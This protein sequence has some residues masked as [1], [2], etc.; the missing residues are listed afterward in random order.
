MLPTRPDGPARAGQPCALETLSAPEARAA[1][2]GSERC[3]PRGRRGGRR[4]RA[5]AGRRAVHRR[6]PERLGAVPG[7]GLVPRRWVRDRLGVALTRHV[8]GSGRRRGVHRHLCRLP[9]A[10]ST[11]SRRLDDALGVTRW[12]RAHAAELGG[13]PDRVAVGGD[14]AGGNLAALC[15]NTSRASSTSSSCTGHRRHVVLRLGTV[16]R[17]GVLLTASTMAWFLDN[18]LGDGDRKDPKP[19]RCS[20]PTSSWRPRR[21]PTCSPPATTRCATRR[22]LCGPSRAG[23]GDHRLPLLRG[24]DARFFSLPGSSGR[25]RGHGAATHELR[26]SFRRVHA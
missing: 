10:P 7:A 1:T 20:P 24:P 14:S 2:R 3:R 12:A 17:R 9:L 8:P 18:Y 5:R 4:R 16:T 13:D 22:G 25:R 19:H 11:R 23:R 6:D 21:A 26:Q 15:A